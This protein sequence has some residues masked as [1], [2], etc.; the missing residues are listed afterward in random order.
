MILKSQDREMTLF[1]Y[2]CLILFSIVFLYYPSFYG[3]VD[4]GHLFFD[5]IDQKNTD[6]INI[7]DN[8]SSIKASLK[9]LHLEKQIGK[10]ASSDFE[11]LREELL[12][13]WSRYEDM[14]KSI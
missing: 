8:I 4:C 2:L 5:D 3:S 14:K 1:A 12:K 11:S 9:D 13:E 7:E 10:L 6:L